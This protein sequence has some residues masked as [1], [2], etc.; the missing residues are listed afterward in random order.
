MTAVP[1]L[2]TFEGA[3]EALGVSARTVRRMVDAGELPYIRIRGAVRL[4][5]D[6]LRAWI[7]QHQRNAPCPTADQA[8]PSGGSPTRTTAARE[9]ESLLAPRTERK[10]RHL[11]LVE[12]SK[13]TA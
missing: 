12:G 8:A 2:L 4:P 6:A 5:C 11:R 3:A 9:L 13:R 1:L 7:A 10:L